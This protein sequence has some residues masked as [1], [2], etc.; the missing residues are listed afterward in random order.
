MLAPPVL[1]LLALL[2]IATG[3][4]TGHLALA[5]AGLVVAVGHLLPGAV[6]WRLVRPER[7]WLVEDVVMG[8]GIGL[9]L[10]V[11]G[12]VLA[13]V[14]GVPA[15]GIALPLLVGAS[16]LAVPAAR[17]RVLSRRCEP[18]PW[19][20]G[21]ATSV[22][23]L[24]PALGAWDAWA[25]RLDVRGWTV[26]YVDLPYHSALAHAVSERFPPHY[27]QVAAERLTYHWFAHAWTAQVSAVSDTGVD[28][29]LWR[30]N[31]ALLAVVVP[32]ATAV[33]AVRITGR[34]WAG[35]A[36]AAVAFL[37]LD[38][39]PWGVSGLS[40]PLASPM[41]PTQQFGML[42]L[43]TLVAVLVL[44]W[45][46]E[47]GARASLPVLL[48]LLVVTG[49]SK[50]SMLPVLVAGAVAAAGVLLLVRRR[51]PLRVVGTDA[52]LA[53]V[54]LLVLNRLM[55]GGGDGGVSLDLGADY[56]AT[57]SQGLLG[58]EVELASALGVLVLVLATLPLVLALL[59]GLALAVDR[60]TRTDPV[61]WLLL[62]GGVAGVGAVVALTHPGGS[63]GYFYK[64]A[65]PLLALAGVWGTVV[66]W[67]RAGAR[68]RLVLAGVVTGPVALQATLLAFDHGRAPGA[69]GA[70]LSVAAL[71]ALVAAGAYAASR[72]SGAGRAGFI[73]TAA[74]A[75][76]AAGVVPTA[77]AVADWER[78]TAI[79]STRPIP[80]GIN[81]TDI[82]VLRWLHDHS[83]R[84]DLVA[85]NKHCLGRVAD[86]C[87]R[88]RF[89]IG[90]YSGRGV[91]IEGWTY[92]RRVAPLYPDYGTAQF[93][94]DQ[95]W[96]QD[97][98][99]LNDGFLTAPGAE[100]AAALWDLGVRWLVVW[101]D[102]P[103]AAD[104]APYAEKVR[105]GRT[106]DVYRLTP[107]G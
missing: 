24:L 2:Q 12:H 92:N 99:A 63:Q 71:L 69:G 81:G 28:Q 44:R 37:L 61:T 8:L 90:A 80:T 67:E 75:L 105:S 72:A 97:L 78:P 57:R 77:H 21:A 42:V 3:P 104:L 86:P 66:L 43:L 91:V 100:G 32:L 96:D 103:H 1:A 14:V 31:P 54:T 55:F 85:T 70:L 15:L 7:G 50:G 23:A 68:P 73:A 94:D 95:F 5:R 20:W 11:P 51:D 60:G 64:A 4:D 89:F 62:G 10:A 53:G 74:L 82:R 41:S 76:L 39:R 46:G 88:R 47:V 106:L 107:A 49:G 34:A 33:V 6:V 25:Q 98:L 93:R 30:F 9:A 59:G 13:V 26:Q 52:L 16:V 102:A 48:L 79:T 36:A 84:G 27:P 45:R 65:E 58:R 38:V 83:E 35:P 101:R 40:N 17:A 29:L 56:V 19:L 22:S 87:D 18:L